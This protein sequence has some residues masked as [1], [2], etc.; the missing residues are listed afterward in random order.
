[1]G[2]Y[3]SKNKYRSSSQ[4]Y[5]SEATLIFAHKKSTESKQNTSHKQKNCSRQAKVKEEKIANESTPK[6]KLQPIVRNFDP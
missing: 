6:E 2:F 5:S 3:A 4:K 1:M